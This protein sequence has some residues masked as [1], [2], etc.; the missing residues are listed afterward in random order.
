MGLPVPDSHS[1]LSGIKAVENSGSPRV[2][3]HLCLVPSL[4]ESQ[5]PVPEIL[6]TSSPFLLQETHDK[7]SR[8]FQLLVLEH[9]KLQKQI[10]DQEARSK[11]QEELHQAEVERLKEDTARHAK[12]HDVLKKDLEQATQEKTKV[13]KQRDDAVAALS[14]RAQNDQKLKQLCKDNEEK[15]QKAE[16]E[17]AQFK[18][19]S[20]EW[21]SQ[22]ILLN[23]EMNSKLSKSICSL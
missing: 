12:L 8:L 18:A 17:L 13:E 23:Q 6:L 4:S 15:T 9:C 2:P 7:R 5:A 22:L 3:F 14:L 20:A 1:S 10:A 16:T 11:R 21:L 19:Q